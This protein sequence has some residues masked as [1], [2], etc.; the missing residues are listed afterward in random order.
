MEQTNREETKPDLVDE[1]GAADEVREVFQEIK[2]TLQVGAVGEPWR[3]FGTKP[4]FLQGVWK[5]LEPAVDEGFMEMADAIRAMAVYRVRESGPIPDHRQHLGSDLARASE[6]LRVFLEA[7]PKQLIL[8]CALRHA[9]NGQAVGGHRTGSPSKRGVP[10]WHPEV[11]EASPRAKTK[12]VLDEITHL[13]DLPAPNTDYLVLAKYP[14]FL[15][16]AWQDLKAFVGSEAWRAAVASVEWVAEQ[17]A[18]AL[19]SK[20]SVSPDRREELGLEKEEVDELGA[21]IETFHETLP[22]LIVNT[23]YLQVAMLGGVELME[24][25]P[26]P[27]VTGEPREADEATTKPSA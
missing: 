19:P 1:K 22:G 2:E 18:V 11:D 20:I 10:E 5:E 14:D 27:E 6:E 7:N 26:P 8:M 3:A 21:W 16:A 13:L 24:A 23:S 4:R 17:A 12:E 25:P 15:E 9:W